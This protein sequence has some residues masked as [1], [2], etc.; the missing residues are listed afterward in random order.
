MNMADMEQ[1][2]REKLDPNATLLSLAGDT[3]GLVQWSRADTYAGGHTEDG[4]GLRVET[5]YIVHRWATERTD[6]EP[7]EGGVMFWS[8]FYTESRTEA[9]NDFMN[10]LEPT[11]R[12]GIPVV[13]DKQEA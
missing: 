8:G 3:H 13:L 1:L 7:V 4:T 9:G 12:D 6:G 5:E 10:R 11:F 2:L